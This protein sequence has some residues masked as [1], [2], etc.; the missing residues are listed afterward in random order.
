MTTMKRGIS[1]KHCDFCG[2]RRQ[3]KRIK[4]RGRICR[5]CSHDVLRRQA[6]GF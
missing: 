2:K 3:V 6:A 5:Q 4:M 1:I